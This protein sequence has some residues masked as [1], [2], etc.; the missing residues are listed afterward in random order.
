MGAI[1]VRARAWSTV[2]GQP[3]FVSAPQVESAVR[4]ASMGWVLAGRLR[5]E[6]T[7]RLDSG[8]QGRCAEAGQVPVHS[9]SATWAYVLWRTRSPMA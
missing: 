7:T 6:S 8:A 9:S 5:S 1:A 2:D 4:S 3:G